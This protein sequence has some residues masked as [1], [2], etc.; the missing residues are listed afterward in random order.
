M[1]D[2]AVDAEVTPGLLDKPLHHAETEATSF[3]GLLRREE[4][5]QNPPLGF[6]VATAENATQAHQRLEQLGRIDVLFTDLGLPGGMNGAELAEE[7]GGAPTASG[8]S[9]HLHHRPAKDDVLRSLPAGT[10]LISKPYFRSTL[11]QER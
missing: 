5:L 3:A 11:A 8:C 2:V 7:G 1:A 4:R 9:H 6:R 10:P